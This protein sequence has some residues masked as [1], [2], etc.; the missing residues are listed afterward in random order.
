MKIQNNKKRIPVEEM[1]PEGA[2]IMATEPVSITPEELMKVYENDRSEATLAR[3]YADA[4]NQASWL[5][6]DCDEPNCP[7]SVKD[8][9]DAWWDISFK[10]ASDIRDILIRENIS[11]KNYVVDNIGIHYMVEPFMDKNGY[12]DGCGW[13][14]LKEEGGFHE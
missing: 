4:S 11:G 14:E 2:V 5:S 9:C 13:W 7:D 6:F 3:C 12:R 8:L 10:L 1:I